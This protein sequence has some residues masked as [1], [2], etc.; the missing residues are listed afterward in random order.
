M[1]AQRAAEVEGLGLIRQSGAESH[2]N[3]SRRVMSRMADAAGLVVASQSGV[4]VR[5]FAGPCSVPC[6]YA[7]RLRA[8]AALFNRA[9]LQLFAMLLALLAASSFAP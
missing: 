6:R 9:K 2:G 7:A 1:A 5:G 8:G 4:G 3:L